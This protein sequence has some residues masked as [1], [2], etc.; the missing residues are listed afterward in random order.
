MLWPNKSVTPYARESDRFGSAFAPYGETTV[1][2]SAP[3]EPRGS[4]PAGEAEPLAADRGL[5]LNFPR[6]V[7]TVLA[8][9]RTRSQKFFSS[10]AGA[11][12]CVR[13]ISSRRR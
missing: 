7:Q 9:R 11:R 3:Q 6:R 8:H 2:R 10:A 12:W 1:Y 5:P 13:P 4:A